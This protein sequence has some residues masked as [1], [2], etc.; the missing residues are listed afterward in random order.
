MIGG[1]E[2]VLA[3][4]A[5]GDKISFYCKDAT[6]GQLNTFISS[7][8]GNTSLVNLTCSASL[9]SNNITAPTVSGTNNI[10]SNTTNGIISIGSNL[11]TG[12][13]DLGT[14]TS[15]TNVYGSMTFS[16]T[17]NFSTIQQNSI[18]LNIENPTPSGSIYL[19]TRPSVGAVQNSVIINASST[20]LANEL[21]SNGQATFNNGATFNS[22]IPTTSISASSANQLVN[23]TTL[24][25]QGY[26]TLA[27]VQGNGNT[28]TS[29]NTF[30]QNATFNSS[31]YIKDATNQSNIDQAGADLQI[32][33]EV[34]SGA[35]NFNTTDSLSSLATRASI[36]EDQFYFQV[37]LTISIGSSLYSS[38][39]SN[40]IGY[41]TTNTGSSQTL[42]STTA[43]NSGQLASL[44]P[45]VWKI[46]Y[47]A[48]IN[49]TT[50]MTT[51]TTIEVF[52]ANSANVDLDIQ[53]LD[54]KNFYGVGV[55]ATQKI[56]ISAS[57][58]LI[59]SG[60]PANYNL[61]LIP[62]FT[63]GAGNFVGSISATRLS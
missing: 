28:F 23:Y 36:L 16:N 21:I 13:I 1:N 62:V 56:K 60:A 58:T 22:V 55:T 61:R 45:G 41:K 18:I 10:Y 59:N 6:L 25:T 37:P 30:T 27:L 4:N 29:T 26:T 44:D 52:V 3:P 12:S 19:K 14:S 31:L 2:F 9:I 53:G 15:T 43:V 38:F 20:T 40:T 34:D 47:T 48:T 7:A 54:V 24:T 8:I 5:N 17:P 35:I 33:N 51:L 32:E 57:G 39:T 63:G 50:T 11:T 49:I 42:T 46:D